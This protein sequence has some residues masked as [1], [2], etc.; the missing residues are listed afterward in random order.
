MGSPDRDLPAVRRIVEWSLALAGD[1]THSVDAG[2]CERDRS[3]E[4][5]HWSERKD[6][7]GLL[8]NYWFEHFYTT[9]FGLSLADYMGKR[10]LDIGYGPRGSLEWATTALEQVGLDPLADGYLRLGAMGTRWC[11]SLPRRS[12]SPFRTATSTLSVRSTRWTTS[13][14]LMVPS[15]R[16]RGW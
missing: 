3:G 13:M 11:T 4:L 6:S 16:S 7:E 8:E 10:A 9:Y 5:A 1:G 15:G 2:S 12:R 14:T